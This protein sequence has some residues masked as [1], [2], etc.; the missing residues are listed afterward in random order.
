[1]MEEAHHLKTTIKQMEAS[2][3]GVGRG[4][5]ECE[6]IEITYPLNR[7][8]EALKEKHNSVSKLHRERFEQ[9]KSMFTYVFT[10][11]KS[12]YFSNKDA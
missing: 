6:G 12:E 2:L 10:Q 7:C 5:R 3:D 9:V 1:M 11:F 4:S 8:L